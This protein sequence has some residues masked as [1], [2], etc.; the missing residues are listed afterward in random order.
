MVCRE[1]SSPQILNCTFY[2]Y[3]IGE[4]CVKTDSNSYPEVTNTILF[5]YPW[6]VTDCVSSSGNSSA[7]IS[8]SVLSQQDHPNEYTDNGNNIITSEIGF[9]EDRYYE[10]SA[11]SPCI[12]AGSNNVEGL[13]NFD[14][15]GNKRIVGSK[16]DIGAFEYHE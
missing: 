11:N 3:S 10:L 1:E 7:L 16:I 13:T 15:D 6:G 9:I 12:D 4:S 8:Y 14:I 5:T 2:V